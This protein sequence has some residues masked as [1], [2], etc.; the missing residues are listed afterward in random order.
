MLDPKVILGDVDDALAQW[1]GLGLHGAALVGELKALDDE[2]KRALQAHDSAKQAQTS[3]SSVF[4]DKSATPEQKAEARQQLQPLAETVKEES[5]NAK[6]ASDAIREKLMGC[7]NWAHES[8]VDGK[9]EDD[10]ELIRTWGERRAFD[11]EPKDHAEIGE[12]L[13]ILDFEAGARVS[14][15]GFVVYRGLGARLERALAAFMLDRHT[16]HGYTEIYAPYLVARHSM[17][18]TGQLPKF[19]E[20]AFATKDDRFLIPTSEVPVTNLH[21][22]EILDEGAL[23]LHYTAY[24]SCF[25]REAGSWGRAT[26]GLIRLHQFQ[27][28]ELVKIVERE[29]SWDELEAM[30]WDAEAILHALE[31]P[32]RVVSLCTG[33]LG[34]S[35]AKT[36]DLEVW[37]PSGDGAW[38]EI[39]SCSNC[40]DFQARR[41]N[42]RYRPGG[43]E[44]PRFAHTLNGSGLA[45]GRTIVALLENHQQADGSV[46]IPEA[47]VPY[48][49]GIRKLE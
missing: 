19:E 17:E 28:V 1:T 23:P 24:S 29:R 8:V 22:G 4:K 45:I 21:R 25:R 5:A 18:G 3:L 13:G 39:S 12:R 14:G 42:I 44:K 38:R 9:T 11:F 20:D 7:D 40:T 48:M 31:L 34:F 46:R 43:G 32:Y 2:R 33:D 47:L 16:S 26:K 36:Y 15:S 41:A 30:V 35:A 27:K 49:G 37:L 10:N 6:A